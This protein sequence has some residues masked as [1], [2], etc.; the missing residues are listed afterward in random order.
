[1]A[2]TLPRITARITP[3]IEDLLHR[4]SALSGVS[5]INAFVLSSAVEKARRIIE[6][7]DRMILN[8]EESLLFCEALEREPVV[9]PRLNKAFQS[10]RNDS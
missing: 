10:Y 2:A 9:H 4:A 3:E 7:E 1:M 5:S 8:R 6:E